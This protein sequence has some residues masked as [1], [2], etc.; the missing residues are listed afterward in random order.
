MRRRQRRPSR[1]LVS[2]VSRILCKRRLSDR[3]FAENAPTLHIER[4]ILHP[5]CNSHSYESSKAV[6]PTTTDDVEAF[7]QM[8]SE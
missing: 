5:E 3:H 7:L 4:S 6:G 1:R 2:R 8:A